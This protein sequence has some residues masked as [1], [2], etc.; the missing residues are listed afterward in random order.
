MKLKLSGTKNDAGWRPDELVEAVFKV[1]K[2]DYVPEGVRV[3]SRINAT[4]FTG[5]LQSSVLEQIEDDANVVSIS[6]SRKLRLID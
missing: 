6:L 1:D 5:E 3:R 4:I 2:A